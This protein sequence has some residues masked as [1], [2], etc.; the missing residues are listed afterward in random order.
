MEGSRRDH[1]AVR[2]NPM[3]G[4][5]AGAIGGGA[6]V[7]PSNTSR[8]RAMSAI[9]RAISPSVSNDPAASLT[10]VQRRCP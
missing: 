10:P 5:T 7:S 2:Q 6:G 3:R 9:L 1:S 8:N 4:G